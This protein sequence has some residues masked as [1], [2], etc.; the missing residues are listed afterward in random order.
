MKESA[1]GLTVL[2]PHLEASGS[3]NLQDPLVRIDGSYRPFFRVQVD[4]FQHLVFRHFSQ[5][6]SSLIQRFFVLRRNLLLH[7]LKLLI[8]PIP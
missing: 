7:C 8:V 5:F 3:N 1:E 2:A 4:E 6:H